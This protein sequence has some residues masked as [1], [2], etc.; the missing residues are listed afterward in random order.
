MCQWVFLSVSKDASTFINKVKE[1]H[2]SSLL[3]PEG[4]GTMNLWNNGIHSTTQHQIREDLNLKH[5]YLYYQISQGW[6]NLMLI[7]LLELVIKLH[8][9]FHLSFV[10]VR[11]CTCLCVH[12]AF[13]CSSLCSNVYLFQHVLYIS[14]KA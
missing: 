12:N 13:M 1:S 14:L 8:L 11:A 4:E 9:I 2:S 3:D 7:L 5:M 10:C 6:I